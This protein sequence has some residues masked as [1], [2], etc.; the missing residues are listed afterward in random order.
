[1]RA[2]DRRHEIVIRKATTAQNSYGEEVET[3]ADLATVRASV[4]AISSREAF[5][6]Q[7][8]RGG[9]VYEFRFINSV[10]VA[11][12]DETCVIVWDGKT[13]DLD[14]PLLVNRERDVLV[15]GVVRS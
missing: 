15:R 13:F 5:Y 4:T 10:D 1:M 7:A 11:D 14:P 9:A 6:A 8:E 2:G 12:L 3:W